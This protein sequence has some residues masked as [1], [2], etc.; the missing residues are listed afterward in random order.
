MFWLKTRVLKMIEITLI[1][2]LFVLGLNCLF[3]S[4]NNSSFYDF[5]INRI[6][7][8]KWMIE[9]LKREEN[10][11]KSSQIWVN[12]CMQFGICLMLEMKNRQ[13]SQKWKWTITLSIKYLAFERTTMM[14]SHHNQHLHSLDNHLKIQIFY[15]KSFLFDILHWFIKKS[16]HW[17]TLSFLMWWI[18]G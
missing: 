1:V 15:D 18:E 16:Q 4:R 12:V 8:W 14:I 17:A 11:W 7:N 6:I 2:E 3:F 5:A 10:W 9:F 13:N